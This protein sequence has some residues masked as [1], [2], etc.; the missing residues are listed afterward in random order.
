MHTYSL[1]LF[2]TFA[3]LFC[4]LFIFY[5]L[6][7]SLIKKQIDDQLKDMIPIKSIRK[8]IGIKIKW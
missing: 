7:K 2:G 3:L 4:I 8:R 5:Q 1:L 6:L